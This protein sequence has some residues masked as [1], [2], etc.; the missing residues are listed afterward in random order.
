MEVGGMYRLMIVDD[1]AL[2]RDVICHSINWN[3][4]GIS[5]VATAIDGQ[6]AL[7]KCVEFN[8]NIVITDIRMPN[9]DGLQLVQ[10]LAELLPEIKTI[11]IS[12]YDEFDY[13]Q[14]AVQFGT[15]DY[16]LK[17][18]SPEELTES[19]R[20]LI[21]GMVEQETK[22]EKHA[23]LA[24]E[25][26]VKQL[27][28][29][30]FRTLV[31]LSIASHYFGSNWHHQSGWR[32]ALLRVDDLLLFIQENQNNEQ[33]RI[34][35]SISN[36]LEYLTRSYD[37]VTFCSY[38]E[39]EWALIML[40]EDYKDILI[41]IKEMIQRILKITVSIAVSASIESV[42]NIQSGL[43]EAKQLLRYRSAL[44]RDIIIE[45]NDIRYLH[46]ERIIT[47]DVEQHVDKIMDCEEAGAVQ[48]IFWTLHQELTTRAYDIQSVHDFAFEFI[49][50]VHR[51]AESLGHLLDQDERH[52]L[53]NIHKQIKLFEVVRDVLDYLKLY[54]MSVVVELNEGKPRSNNIY[55]DRCM[56]LFQTRYKENLSLAAI[57]LEL[58][59]TP[60]YLSHLFKQ[61]LGVTFL[62][63]LTE[64]RM[65]KAK[66][67]LK[68]SML[69]NYEIAEQI[70]F[71][72][73]EYFAKVFKRYTGISPSDYRN[74]RSS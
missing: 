56:S 44:G 36:I 41:D 58:E 3:D 5:E 42:S 49:L 23:E 15:C 46:L 31:D 61:E 14:K 45:H 59:I 1:D 37:H 32:I 64:V 8:P 66:K 62:D 19:V 57:A 70:G 12:G 68:S 43:K 4:I 24:R 22:M 2:A 13:A 47:V 16:L 51:K 30:R 40:A 20:R 28:E 67:L 18:C 55:I 52:S 26:V 72:S 10:K 7:Q 74:T 50:S 73:P 60:N 29:G 33:S 11:I 25:T 65:I 39:G 69:R 34:Q 6:D 17:P 71:N 54:V 38:G 21:S 27:L 35:F 9:M 53:L 63:A 48:S